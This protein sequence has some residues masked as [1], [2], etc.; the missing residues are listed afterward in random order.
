MGFEERPATAGELEQMKALVEEA[1]RQG[2]V[3]LSSAWHSG[4]YDYEG[5]VIELARIAAA[6][7][8]HYGTHIGSEGFE[9]AQELDKAIRVGETTGIRV[10]VY[11]LK[12][13]GKPNWGRV[14]E[15]IERIE[16]AR[17][18]GLD[19][20]ANQYPYTA[21][22]HPWHRLLPRWVQ[23]MPPSEAAP[24]FADSDFRARVRSDPEFDQYIDEH[25]GWEGIVGA[26]F[27]TPELQEY[28]GRTVAEIASQWEADPVDVCFELIVREGSFPFGV[29]HNMSDEDVQVVMRQPWVSIASDGSAI[30]ERAPGKPHP[31]AYGTNVRVLGKYVRDDG[32]ITLEDAVRKMTSLPAQVLGLRDRGV[33]REGCWA[34]LVIFDPAT[35]GDA[36]TFQHPQQYA[37]GVPYVLV[38]GVPVIDRGEHRD[39]RPGMVVTG[40]GLRAPLSD[41]RTR[42]G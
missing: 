9:L 19:V 2:A 28:E 14:R 29:Y 7:D 25:G 1:M 23:D 13:R 15:A 34:D 33:V 39:T 5:E 18:R 31:R 17:N 11:H 38:N 21:M 27:T 22:Q 10:H 12:A 36:A 32:V 35:V 42:P 41:H 40:P 8:G 37:R 16:A 20:T 3:G 30:N 6:Y 26:R 4:G 24:K